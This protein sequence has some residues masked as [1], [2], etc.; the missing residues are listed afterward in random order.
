MSLNADREDKI[1][2]LCRFQGLHDL[3]GQYIILFPVFLGMLYVI[4]VFHRGKCIKAKILVYDITVIECTVM[5]MHRMSR[6]TKLF[7]LCRHRLTGCTSKYRLIWI[8]TGTEVCHIKSG[9][10][11]KF[12]ICCSRSDCR[13]RKET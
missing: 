11:L 4:H 7:K 6:I 13:H 9:K 2:V 10:H 3:S 5:V 12:R 1:L 8:F